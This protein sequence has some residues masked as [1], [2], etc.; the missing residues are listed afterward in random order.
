WPAGGHHVGGGHAWQPAGA[1]IQ[2]Q[3]SLPDQ[4][5]A[6]VAAEGAKGKA[7][8]RC[9]GYLPGFC[10]NSCREV[11]RA[12]LGGAGGESGPADLP[13]AAKAQ[14]RRV[15]YAAVAARCLAFSFAARVVACADVIKT[16]TNEE[17]I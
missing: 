13:G 16:N 12:I 1:G 6:G 10:E 7:R 2:C 4:L 15:R 5:P 8:C 3:Q 17:T 11:A 14:A 9:N